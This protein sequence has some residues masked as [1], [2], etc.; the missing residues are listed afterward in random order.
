MKF[1][2]RRITPYWPL[3]N[4]EAERFMQ[5]YKKVVKNA[6][7]NGRSNESFIMK[8]CNVLSFKRTKNLK[9][10]I[11]LYQLFQVFFI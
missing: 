8:N 11:P 9:N 3:Y 7:I 10:K 5:N 2:H 6:Q 1:L 4:G